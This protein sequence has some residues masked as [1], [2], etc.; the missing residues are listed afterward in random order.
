VVVSA[1]T[2]L[3]KGGKEK[4]F[5]RYRG[6]CPAKIRDRITRSVTQRMF[7]IQKGDVMAEHV[8]EFTECPPKSC[9]FSILGSTG[10]CYEV[11]IQ[12]P[13]SCTCPD[14]A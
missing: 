5:K 3:K 4:R 12:R 11:K 13:P 14:H 7:L 8:N 1:A 10:N 2:S 6:S 9:S